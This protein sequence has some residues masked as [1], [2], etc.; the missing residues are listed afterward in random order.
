PASLE[1]SIE[2][3]LGEAIVRTATE[4]GLSLSEAQDFDSP[5][6]KGVLGRVGGRAVV[7]GAGPFL[8]EQGVDS[9]ELEAAAEALRAEGATAVFAAVD[10]RLAGLIGIADPIK[11]TTPAAVEAL[12]RAG[13]RIVMMTGDTRTTAQAIAARLGIS[14]VES[15]VLPQDKARVVQRLR[16]EGRSVAMAGDGVNDAPALAAAEV[17]IAMGAG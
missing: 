7:V 16:A 8:A 14:E 9:A 17:G 1:R 12:R 13:I 2:H 3:P 5:V 6:G 15:E 4:R 10:G 11:P